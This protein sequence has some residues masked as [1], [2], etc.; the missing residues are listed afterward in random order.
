[1]K[2]QVRIEDIITLDKMAEELNLGKETI[3]IWRQ[4]GMPTIKIGKYLR[5]YR[6]HVFDWIVTQ[7]EALEGEE[8]KMALWKGGKNEQS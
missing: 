4:K 3:E 2:K 7:G 6:P 1:M 5:V 8:K